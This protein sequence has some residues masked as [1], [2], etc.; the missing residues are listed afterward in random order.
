MFWQKPSF[1]IL[2]E[3]MWW[4]GLQLGTITIA[5]STILR[6][7]KQDSEK[8]I[9]RQSRPVTELL[10]HFPKNGV[11]FSTYSSRLPTHRTA[12]KPIYKQLENKLYS[13]CNNNGRRE[14]RSAQNATRKFILVSIHWESIL[15]SLLFSNQQLQRSIFTFL[16]ESCSC[17]KCSFFKVYKWCPPMDNE[18][19]KFYS[20]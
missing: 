13:K 20:W 1:C 19:E 8:S 2:H 17:W 3:L 18:T 11:F 16:L 15:I 7:K 10:V 6:H 14:C 12:W 5:T 9:Q 4:H